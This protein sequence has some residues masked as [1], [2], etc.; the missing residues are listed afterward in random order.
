M[1]SSGSPIASNDLFDI[2]GV[3]RDGGVDTVITCSGPLD[4]S[5]ETLSRLSSKVRGYLSA[6]ASD[7]FHRQYGQGPVRIFVSCSHCVST[8]ARE[9]MSFL[10]REA[11]Q[12][13][14]H[15]SLGDPVA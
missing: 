6:V 9:T 4:N 8:E 10:E 14:V 7:E 2:V 5:P 1:T 13:N 11:A 15:L 12:Q 3:R